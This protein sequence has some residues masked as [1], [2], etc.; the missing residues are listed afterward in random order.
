MIADYAG[1]EGRAGAVIFLENDTQTT[2]KS[3]K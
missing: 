1:S 2:A 3:K